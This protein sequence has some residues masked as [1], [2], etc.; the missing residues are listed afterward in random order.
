MLIGGYA[1]FGFGFTVLIGVYMGLG[2]GFIVLI[3]VYTGFGFW[4]YSVDRGLYGFRVS[5][6][7]C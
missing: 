2:F 1:G 6:L 7:Q 3:G 4:A 5:G